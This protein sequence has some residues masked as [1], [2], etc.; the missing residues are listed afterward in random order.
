MLYKTDSI[1]KTIVIKNSFEDL[2]GLNNSKENCSLNSILLFLNDS[3]TISQTAA[4][5]AHKLLMC[6]IAWTAP[7]VTHVR[8]IFQAGCG[9]SPFLLLTTTKF[10]GY[11][12]ELWHQQL[13][14]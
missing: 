6:A 12:S 13:L 11:S 5:A 1:S 2:L 9:Q 10:H 8:K 4:A 7:V 14:L 3:F